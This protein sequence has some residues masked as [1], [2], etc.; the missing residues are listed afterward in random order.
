MTYFL[1]W[2]GQAWAKASVILFALFLGGVFFSAFAVQAQ[3]EGEKAPT[4]IEEV[5]TWLLK[6]QGTWAP[7]SINNQP[8]PQNTNIKLT[9]DG[10][11]ISGN[12]GCNAFWGEL[13]PTPRI[14][15]TLRACDGTTLLLPMDWSDPVKPLQEGLLSYGVLHLRGSKGRAVLRRVFEVMDEDFL[16]AALRGSVQ[17]LRVLLRRGANIDVRDNE[18][19]TSLHLAVERGHFDAAEFLLQVGAAT[20]TVDNQGVSPL[21][22]SIVSGKKGFAMASLLVEHRANV[23]RKGGHFGDTALHWAA[24]LG[25]LAVADLLVRYGASLTDCGWSSRSPLYYAAWSGEL[26]LVKF[27]V[28]GLGADPNWGCSSEDGNMR[29]PIEGAELESQTEVV[30]FLECAMKASDTCTCS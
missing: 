12:D 6:L 11:H 1:N 4:E 30:E 14:R 21:H 17:D 28:A 10:V 16:K 29:L 23:H 9:I 3:Q 22:S 13:L 20:D 24:E 19:H 2:R 18:G 8:T 25:N 26:T 15:H 5:P 27:L 7:E